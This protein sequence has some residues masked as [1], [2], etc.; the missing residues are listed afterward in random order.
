MWIFPARNL[1]VNGSRADMTQD[2][3]RNDAPPSRQ[4]HDQKSTHIGGWSGHHQ[5]A[6]KKMVSF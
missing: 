3:K 2:I 5:Y 1:I 4:S 6:T